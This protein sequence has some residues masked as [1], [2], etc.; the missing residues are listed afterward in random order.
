M[1]AGRE[2][3]TRVRGPASESLR[4]TNPREGDKRLAVYGDLA[5]ERL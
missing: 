2:Q 1:P 3:L 4:W 5:P